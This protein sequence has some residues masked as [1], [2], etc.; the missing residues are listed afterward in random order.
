MQFTM[1]SELEQETQV[2]QLRVSERIDASLTKLESH[3]L[4]D[5]P[6]DIEDHQSIIGGKSDN[7]T[8]DPV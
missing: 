6:P 1:G 3:L 2:K 8:T 5:L 7:L 4:A